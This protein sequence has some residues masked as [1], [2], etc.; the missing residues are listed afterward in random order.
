MIPTKEHLT[1]MGLFEREFKAPP[2]MI[3]KRRF[4]LKGVIC[5]T[6]KPNELFL[7]LAVAAPT[8]KP[9]QDHP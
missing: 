7:A 4:G 1:M 3:R 5:R 2:P 8:E 9:A 6:A